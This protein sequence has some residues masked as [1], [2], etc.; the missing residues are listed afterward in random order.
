MSEEAKN[1][2]PVGVWILT[3]YLALFASVLPLFLLTFLVV[4]GKSTSDQLFLSGPSI[5]IS[6]FTG[7]GVLISA[8]AAWQGISWGRYALVAFAALHYGLVSANNFM[9]LQNETLP[10]IAQLHPERLWGRVIRGPIYIAVVAW[11]FLASKAA[12]KFYKSPDSG[13]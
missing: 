10:D 9:M 3:I 5:L 6:I 13:P 4:K 12:K 2:R 8:V 1:K 7:V 11:Y